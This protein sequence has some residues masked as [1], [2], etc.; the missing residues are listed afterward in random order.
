MSLIRFDANAMPL[1]PGIRLLEASAGTGKTFTLN[2]L[3]VILALLGIVSLLVAPT[4]VAASLMGKGV[5]TSEVV[6]ALLHE[7]Y[8]AAIGGMIDKLREFGPPPPPPP[9]AAAVLS[10]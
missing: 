7:R 1:S 3:V 10:M 8:G 6:R 5:P 2:N 9:L 4:G